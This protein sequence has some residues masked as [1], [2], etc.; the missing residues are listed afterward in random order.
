MRGKR[1]IVGFVFT[2]ILVMLLG[3]AFYFLI[4]APR[5]QPTPEN[6]TLTPTT[7]PSPTPTPSIPI[8]GFLPDPSI[9]K[10]K[11]LGA[12]FIQIVYWLE[13]QKSGNVLPDAYSPDPS[14]TEKNT[15]LYVQRVHDAGLKV[16]LQIYPEFY[17]L[18]M[19]Y[20]SHA[21]E[22]E[23]GPV[24]DQPK[25]MREMT[26]VALKWARTAEELKV[27]LFSPACELNIFVDW[28]NNVKWHK[29]ILPKLRN[30]YSGE[31]VQKGELVW[32]KYKLSPEGDLTFY[33]H[34]AGW[35]YVNSDIYE[36]DKGTRSFEDYRAYVK[37]VIS[38]LMKLK[39]IHGSKGII[40][41]EIGLPE[42][43]ETLTCF[44]KEHGLTPEE[45]ELQFPK[46]LLDEAEGKV[47]GFFFWT[48]NETARTL[49]GCYYKGLGAKCANEVISKFKDSAS[50][51]VDRAEDTAK[52]MEGLSP[53]AQDFLVKAK[54]AFDSG[55]YIIAKYWANEL[56]NLCFVP[57][58]GLIIDGYEDDWIQ[59][60]YQPLAI[61]KV[62][63]VP[64]IGE[65]LKS[66]FVVNDE[67]NLYFMIRFADKPT[68]DVC[69]FFDINGDGI[70][71]YSIRA[72]P[73][74]TFLAKTITP[75]YHERIAGLNSGYEQVVEFKVPLKLMGNPTEI[76]VQIASWSNKTNELSDKM[77]DFKWIAYSVG[78]PP[79]E[80]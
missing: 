47:D 3:G 15:I 61:D 50:Q 48:K 74:D 13:V 37:E 49:I 64:D 39:E 53:A 1:I 67:E 8:R 63:D 75:G 46:I 72:R 79:S 32:R 76:R 55:E 5:V 58:L 38:E 77:A 65:D 4:L 23:F 24:E 9:F 33:D 44:L 36:G 30:V 78:R 19:A 21:G 31:I 60:G 56:S 12:N 80:S 18:R 52:Q 73:E 68:T 66:V 27:E 70:W 62:G 20:G 25:F 17:E 6:K 41:G 40:L 11:E 71:D 22:L 29:E 51:A 45:Y 42:D 7:F 59:R 34:Y 14:C 54:E 26:E 43:K 28:E 2:L 35:D 10:A 57:S 69:L 16:Y